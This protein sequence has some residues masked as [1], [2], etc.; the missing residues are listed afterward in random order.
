M[1]NNPCQQCNKELAE[2]S[3]A[4]ALT[5]KQFA[6]L[7]QELTAVSKELA[8]AYRTIEQQNKTY[9]EFTNIAAHELRTPAQAILG[10]AG[11]AKRNPADQE[12]KE[13]AIDGIY[14]NAFRLDRLI[15][16]ILDVT[17]IEGHTLQLHKF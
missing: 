7:N 11:I 3:K 16:N 1:Q 12:D 10:Y 9:A 8:L 2:T 5:N 14:R 17:R 15:N 6:D 13:G 4:F